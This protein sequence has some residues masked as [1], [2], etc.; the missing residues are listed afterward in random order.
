MSERETALRDITQ[1][2]KSECD[3]R[4]TPEGWATLGE[5][6]DETL[7]PFLDR[8]STSQYWSNKR[9]RHV[10]LRVVEDV[11]WEAQRDGNN[12]PDPTRLVSADDLRKRR[13]EVFDSYAGTC[14]KLIT[15]Q[16]PHSSEWRVRFVVS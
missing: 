2:I 10:I 12:P 16:R 9:F 14:K 7:G 1:H 11:V 6:F 5:I 8:N 15:D 4:T 3:L 13:G